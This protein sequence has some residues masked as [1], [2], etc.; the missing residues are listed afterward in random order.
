ML[1]PI[2]YIKYSYQYVCEYVALSFEMY[3]TELFLF[4]LA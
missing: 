1:G 3:P 2:I 4:E